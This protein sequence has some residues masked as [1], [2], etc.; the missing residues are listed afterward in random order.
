MQRQTCSVV[1]VQPTQLAV[2]PSGFERAL[3]EPW[4]LTKLRG[5]DEVRPSKARLGLLCRTEVVKRNLPH[6]SSVSFC[7][8]MQ[9]WAATLTLQLHSSSRS[10]QNFRASLG[11][12]QFWRSWQK[13]TSALLMKDPCICLRAMRCI[14]RSHSL[15]GS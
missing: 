4:Q 3:E 8:R 9:Q 6:L 1:D 5:L 2:L 14:L 13:R 7:S 12:S 15:K 11:P 10:P